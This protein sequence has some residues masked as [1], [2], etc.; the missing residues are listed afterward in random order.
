VVLAHP[1][2][3]VLSLLAVDEVHQQTAGKS[4]FYPQT[5]VE[6]K[7]RVEISRFV[8]DIRKAAAAP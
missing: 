3:E 8:P 1:I 7:A 6:E 5:A 4:K 2:K